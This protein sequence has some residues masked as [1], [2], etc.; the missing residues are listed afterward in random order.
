M[1]TQRSQRRIFRARSAHNSAAGPKDFLALRA[2]HVAFASSALSSASF[3]VKR[4]F[5]YHAS[6]PRAGRAMPALAPSRAAR[7]S[8]SCLSNIALAAALRLALNSS[9]LSPHH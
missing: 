6:R 2:G 4:F 7:C 9:R 8:A 1:D 3:A 5:F